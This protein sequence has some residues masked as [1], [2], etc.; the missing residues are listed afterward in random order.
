MAASMAGGCRSSLYLAL[1]FRTPRSRLAA[2]VPDT[3]HVR[4]GP[5]RFQSTGT[6]DPGGFKPPPKPVIVDRRRAPDEQSRFLSPEFIPP[7]GRTN[8]LKFQLE[9]KDMLDRRKVLHIPEFYV[10]SIL[11]VT[12]A[13][14]YASGKTSQF[15][16]ICIQR[17]GNGL[18]ATFTLRNTIEGQ[19]VEICFELYNPR[20]HEI[21]VVKLEKR[22]DDSLLYLRDALPEFST[23]DVT[24]KP[25]PLQSGQEVPVNKLKVK[26]KPKPWSKRWERPKFNIKGIRF[27]LA[28]TEEQMKEA[29]KWSQP[30]LEFDMMREYDTSKIEA[31]LWEEIEASNKS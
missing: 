10:G 30:W 4:K 26:M 25:V 27:D 21:Q 22:L 20:I 3:C 24:M 1:G 12:T 14:P 16:G 19:G 28:L 23:F 13:D 17:S 15:L 29:Q 9:R 2:L 7:R 31:A 5:S 8:P 11:R 6:S 18:G